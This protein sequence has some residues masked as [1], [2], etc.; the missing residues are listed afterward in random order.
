MVVAFGL[1]WLLRDVP[2]RQTAGA[3]GLGGS[4]P[5]RARRAPKLA[6]ADH[7]HRRHPERH[8]T[9][10]LSPGVVTECEDDSTLRP[11][12]R[13]CRRSVR[14]RARASTR[15]PSHTR[16]QIN[17]TCRHSP[18]QRTAS[19]SPGNWPRS[20]REGAGVRAGL[21]MKRILGDAAAVGNATAHALAVR[22]GDRWAYAGVYV[23]VVT[24]LRP[25]APR[26]RFLLF[27]RFCAT[28]G[29]AVR[30]LIMA[31]NDGVPRFDSG[32]RLSTLS[33]TPSGMP[34]SRPSRRRL[35]DR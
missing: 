31:R 19:N 27:M 1:S 11:R 30:Q 20:A 21:R 25:P 29:D 17:A 28:R 32:R 12:S 6:H 23:V 16:P 34:R 26:S 33:A 7:Q 15:T 4:S 14:V 2:L 9:G 13:P 10:F 24:G 8:L 18:S 35:R 5:R 3:P 22:G